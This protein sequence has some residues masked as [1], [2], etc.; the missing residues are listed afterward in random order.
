[1]GLTSS[2]AVANL[3]VRYASRETP[4][5][6]GEIW[7]KEDDL[8]DPYQLNQR[9]SP[10]EVENVMVNQF[11][12]DDLLFSSPSEERALQILTEG[13][14]R[15]DRYQLNLCKVRSNSQLIRDQ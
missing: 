13:I 3:I 10:D 8:L 4:P 5:A 11:Y 15:L 2:P 1:M 9:R 7:I 6:N 12:V 14:R